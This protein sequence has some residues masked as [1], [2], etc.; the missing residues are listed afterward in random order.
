MNSKELLKAKK[1]AR[2]LL[3]VQFMPGDRVRALETTATNCYTKGNIYTVKRVSGPYITVYTEL[4][5]RG[6]S[7]NGWGAYNFELVGD[8]E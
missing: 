6:S 5:D 2:R 4:D 3:G 1:V 8:D 7:D